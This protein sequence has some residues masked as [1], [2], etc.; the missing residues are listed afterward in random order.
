MSLDV[1]SALVTEA[2]KNALTYLRAKFG[3]EATKTVKLRLD[4]HMKEVFN[5]SKDV[6]FHGMSLAQPTDERTVALNFSTIPRRFR[7]V[8]DS[9][10]K[11]DEATLLAEPHHALLLGD[12]GSGK[13]TTLK[14][15]TRKILLQ[16]PASPEDIWQYPL[17]I[18]LGNQPTNVSI[19][20]IL[21]S[22]LGLA[23]QVRKADE[24]VIVGGR[25]VIM[26]QRT[27]YFYDESLETLIPSLL[28]ST[29]AILMFDGLDEIPLADRVSLE[30]SIAELSRRLTFAKIILT[31]RSGEHTRGFEGFRILELCP[32]EVEQM[33]V[34]AASWLPNTTDFMERLQA[35]PF[36]DLA[37]RPL[38]LCQLIVL[39]QNTGQLPAEPATIYRRVITLLL[40]D[41]DRSRRVRRGSRYADFDVDRK[42]EFLAALSYHLTYAIQR[43]RFDREHLARCYRAIRGRFDLPPEEGIEVVREIETHT[44]IIVACGNESFEFSHISLQEYLCAYYL[45]REPFAEHL[46][47]YIQSYPA[48]LAVAVSLASNPSNWFAALIL[49]SGRFVGITK[50]A[51]EVLLSRLVQERPRFVVSENLGVACL[52]VVFEFGSQMERLVGWLIQW[53][54]VRESIAKVLGS[55]SVDLIRSDSSNYYLIL[56]HTPPR[57]CTFR[58]PE[59][60]NFPKTLWRLF[61]EGA[62]IQLQPVETG[63]ARYRIKVLQEES[64]GPG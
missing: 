17:V 55:Y 60:G 1:I 58:V 14:R 5:W 20:E 42:I 10:E 29:A 31:S 13:T 34:I 59:R 3:R 52:K 15:L 19:Y 49:G 63:K 18:L 9:A 12:P 38:F 39:Y 16:E 33:E 43:K 32:L 48:P 37:S 23:F 47:D 25:S 61:E 22:K 46:V 40:E 54:A 28:D 4:V 11:L 62:D 8:L 6:Q 45:V 51:A 36:A 50:E 41:W 27:A 64:R 53:P 44:G 21:S 7:E 2:T 56:E 30:S 24:R 35:L 57:E 26:T